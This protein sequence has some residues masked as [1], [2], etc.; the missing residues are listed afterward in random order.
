MR[1]SQLHLVREAVTREPDAGRY[2]HVTPRH[3][4]PTC[5]KR[6]HY[7]ARAFDPG[8][9]AY[10]RDHAGFL[11]H[12]SRR[13]REHRGLLLAGDYMRGASLEACVRSALDCV[14]QIE[15]ARTEVAAA[16]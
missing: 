2:V 3:L 11:E 14:G 16:A 5:A 9:C 4:P 6:V 13:L 10:R 1:T 8:L 12:A 15:T 7:V